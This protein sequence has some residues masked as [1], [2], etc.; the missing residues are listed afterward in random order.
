MIY[1]VFMLFYIVLLRGDVPNFYVSLNNVRFCIIIIFI[2]IIIYFTS[3]VLITEGGGGSLH[4]KTS[5]KNT[6]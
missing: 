3:S 1:I 6:I 2:I 4:R 5:Y